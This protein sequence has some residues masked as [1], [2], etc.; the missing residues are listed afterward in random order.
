MNPSA[1]PA[2]IEAAYERL[3]KVYDP[4]TSRKRRASERK[5]ELDEAYEVLSDPKAR[6][7]YDRLRAKGYR[8]GEAPPPATGVKAAG[9]KFWDWLD[10]PYVFAGISALGVVVILGAIVAVSLFGGGGGSDA[11]V[12]QPTTTVIPGPT[13]TIPPQ[14]PGTPPASPPPVEGQPVTTASGLQYIDIAPGAGGTAV[15]GDKL[16]VNYTGWLQS[17]GTMFDSSIDNTEP[18]SFVLGAGSVIKGWDEGMATMQKG[19]KRRLIIPP[20]L[21]YGASGQ[22][23]IP[24]NAT[25][26]F[27]VEVVEIFPAATPAPTA[28]ATPAPTAEVSPSP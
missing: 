12:A 17:D 22:G 19:G 16:A 11:V 18:F 14:T 25:L 2:E 8:P 9:Q 5:Q 26:I 21:A 13:A 27:D 20:E 24:P 15:N 23:T 28:A 10:N 4:E 6:A 1:K 7:E 3:S